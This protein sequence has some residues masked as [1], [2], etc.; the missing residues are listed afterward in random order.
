MLAGLAA[1]LPGCG[2]AGTRDEIPARAEPLTA[3]APVARMAPFVWG[4]NGHP[5][6]H[7][8]AYGF[9]E[10]EELLRRQ[11]RL[12]TD[13]GFSHYRVDVGYQMDGREGGVLAT[14]A[15]VAERFG[16]TLLPVITFGATEV[17]RTPEHAYR[18]GRAIGEAF[19]RRHGARFPVVEVGN[20]LDIPA[21]IGGHPVGD[22]VDHYL[23]AHAGR[24][25][26][27]LRGIIEGL[28][29]G[30]PGVRTIVNMTQSHTGFLRILME[31]EVPFDIIGWHLYVDEHGYGNDPQ[32]GA[33]YRSTLARLD[34]LGRDIWITEVNR[35]QG[36]GPGNAFAA[37]QSAILGRLADE[38]YAH[39]RVQAFIVYEL[40]DEVA[41]RENHDRAGRPI[42]GD[43]DEAYYGLVHC[44]G[45]LPVARRCGGTLELKPGFVD[46]R[47]RL[48]ALLTWNAATRATRMSADGR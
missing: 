20:E 2:G 8:E 6:R 12:I 3:P 33:D 42:E 1:L 27:I 31:R 37:E 45:P 5:A 29:A 28:Q 46:A 23:P 11:M 13:L 39:P 32:H 26:G 25:A 30:A 14:V 4:V 19:A 47:E 22:A 35:Y 21:M 10:N 40:Y 48:R 17:P 16:V 18:A 9:E 41:V 7:S 44:E 24:F 36:S 38:M 15:D 34:A 43:E